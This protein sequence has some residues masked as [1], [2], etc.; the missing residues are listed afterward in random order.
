LADDTSCAICGN[1]IE[2]GGEAV[3]FPGVVLNEKDPL[4]PLSDA[5]CHAACVTADARGRAMLAASEAYDCNTGP[6]RRTCAVCGGE[7]LV[8]DDYIL[9]PWLGDPVADPLGAFSYTH[10]HASHVRDWKQADEF[11]AL[12]KAAVDGGRWQG[13]AL[14]KIVQDIA[15]R[16][17]V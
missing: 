5:V 11:L 13:D 7:L 3:L 2:R 4:Y 12:A 16:R 17:G 14:L 9:I 1:M 15:A 8:A 6:G 10:M